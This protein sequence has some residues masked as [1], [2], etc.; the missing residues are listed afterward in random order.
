[1]IEGPVLSASLYVAISYHGFGAYRTDRPDSQCAAVAE[2][3]ASLA[4]IMAGA[5]E[6]AAPLVVDIGVGANWDEAH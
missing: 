4:S 5:A 2:V 1:M 3:R 6:L